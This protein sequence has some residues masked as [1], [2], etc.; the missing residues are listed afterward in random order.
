MGEIM[1]S[2]IF[3]FLLATL[4]GQHAYAGSCR[5][6]ALKAR[7]SG[8]KHLVV[9]FEGLASYWAG[10]VRKG[11]IK[12]MQNKYGATFVSKNYSYGSTQSAESCIR[13]FKLVMGSDLHLSVI[14]HSFGAG[15]AVFNLLNE[16]KD[17]SVNEVV[18]MDPRTWS[19]D[20]NYRRMKTL[21]LFEKPANVA[22]QMNFYQTGGMRGYRV[23]GADNVQV[24]GTTHV[25]MPRVKGIH[26]QVQCFVFGDCP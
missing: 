14:G 19:T 3:V 8:V 5:S 17:I 2:K 23:V 1:K 20:W 15:I 10:F 21:D 11:L 22:R 26:Q 24:T 12:P 16:I 6:E 7:D 13:D 18:T 25:G 4:I 9:S